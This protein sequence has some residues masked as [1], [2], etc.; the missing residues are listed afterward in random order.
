MQKSSTILNELREIT[1]VVADLPTRL[2][3][4]VRGGYFEQ[5]ADKLV[6]IAK[7]A[8]AESGIIN[9]TNY[10]KLC[11]FTKAKFYINMKM[12]RTHCWKCVLMLASILGMAQVFIA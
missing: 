5:L 7:S 4:E 9:K 1:Q 2:P 12:N 6:V 8:D 10:P 3:Y 11:I